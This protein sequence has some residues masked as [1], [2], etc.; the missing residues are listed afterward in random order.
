MSK[1]AKLFF[2]FFLLLVVFL[3]YLEATE[4]E[5]VNWT[6]SY[7]S[8]DKI[9]L[10]SLVFYESWGNTKKWEM[11]EISIPPFE[12]LSDSLDNGTYFFLNNSAFFD[13]DELDKLLNWVNK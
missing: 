2:G 5:P 3:T 12:K 10:G 4:P 11:Q 1:T 7:M 6:P 13:P 8:D 9:P